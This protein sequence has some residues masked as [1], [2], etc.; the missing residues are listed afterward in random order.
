MQSDHNVQRLPLEGTRIT[1]F[2]HVWAGP[3]VTQWLAVMGAEVIKIESTLRPDLTR[4]SFAGGRKLLPGLNHSVDFAVLNL[5]KRSCTINMTQPEGRDIAKELVKIS[6]VVTEN[7]GG[8]VMERWGMSYSE[9]AKIKPDIIMYSGSGFGRRGPYSDFPA[10]APIV[11]SFVGFFSLNGYIGGEPCP[12]GIGGWTDLTAAQH[13]AF[14][15]LAA[16]HHRSRTGEGQYIDLSMSE[17]V[18]A[19]IPDVIMDYTMNNRVEGLQ[20]NR[21]HVMAPHGCYRC[22]GDDAWVAIAVSSDE[23]WQAFC[24]V[25]GNP[26]WTRDERFQDNLSRWRNQ[27]EL[28]K[29]IEEWSK[30]Q[31]QDVVVSTMQEAGVMAAPSLKT[32]EVVK[33]C[34]LRDREFFIDIDM[35][36]MGTV[37]VARL[38]W[39]LSDMPEGN[40]EHAP[41]I[42]EDN[43]YVFK[44]LL[45]M[46]DEEVAR[47]RDQQVIV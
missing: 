38:P 34:N 41:S 1:D 19:F 40:Y 45:H 4:S 15:I 42:G 24:H 23:E 10:Y 14:A 22:Q 2:C 12:Y 3:H 44:G 25:L 27:D 5:G 37:S 20:G 7:F 33:D 36:E 39:R 11:D 47:L 29:L 8:P 26:E 21:D 18:G 31:A 35:P 13:G 9:L 28:D 43:D 16:L 32:E 17:V 46:S 30:D 6:D